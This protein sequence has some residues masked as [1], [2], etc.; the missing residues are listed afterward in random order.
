VSFQIAFLI[1]LVAGPAS[2]S[3][4]STAIDI[5]PDG[6]E[7]WVVNP[8]H[9]SVSVFGM[10]GGSA[11][12]L[13]AEI[14]VGRE[15]W[16]VDV[17][18][19][20]G[21][22]W[23]TSMRDDH[24]YILDG[25]SRTVVDSVAAGFETFGVAFDP[26]GTVA[27][28]T[29]SGSDEI[30]VVDVASRAITHTFDVYR[31]P[32]GIA[33]SHDGTRA[34]VS[35]LLMPEYFGKLT[36][37]DAGSWT[38]TQINLQ[39]VFGL[40]RGGYLSSMQNIALAP[41][42]G[43]SILW[44]PNTLINT[45]S[46]D[47]SGHPLTPTNTFHAVV[48]PINVATNTDLNWDTYFLSEGGTPNSGFAGGTTPVGGP[49]AV[50]FGTS[51][52]YVANL[53]SE[54]VTVLGR[55]ILAPQELT[56]LPAGRAPIGV[57]IHT[58]IARVYVANWLS[59]D[60]TV[61]NT[62]SGT[63]VATVPTTTSEVLSPQ[64]LNGKQFFFTSTGDMSLED[65]GSCGSC[66]V[67]GRTDGRP[68]D[69]SQFGTHIRATKDWRGVG[70]TGPLLWSANVD[71]TQDF[72]WT[73]RDIMGGAGLIP[74]TPNPA[75]GD[76]NAGLSQDLDDIAF[77]V[78]VQQQRPDTPFLLPDGS[79]TAEA[80]S[81][82]ILFNDPSVACLVCHPPP[83]FTDSTFLEDPWI[84]HDVGTADSTDT[85]GTAGYDTPSLVG[86]WDSAPYLHHHR[87]KTLEEMMT[88]LNPD[89]RH[90][91]TSQLSPEQIGFLAAYVKSIG[92]PDSPGPPTGAPSGPIVQAPRSFDRVFPNPFRD[93]TS[94]RF[95]VEG[96]LANVRI[97]V[98]D[99]TGRRV[100]DLLDR[101]LTRGTHV[102]GWDSRDQN[103][104]PVA[105]GA[106]FA[107][108]LVDDRR[109]GTKRMTV[110]R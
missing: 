81:G 105:S 42:P 3:S 30:F 41:A 9:A 38:L 36:A 46:G 20:N 29:A 83:F 110:L 88:T 28:V 5:S 37:I 79:L 54:N 12:M 16:C 98:F 94:L 22:V 45:K 52:A 100:R 71:E 60:V 11:N 62:A 59:R 23:V 90:G 4:R 80:D 55:D 8:D 93:E 103:G 56:V 21:E 31:R 13:L 17:H 49:V 64:V 72:E 50:A 51:R 78:S 19:T 10:Q 39:Q 63:V 33:W 18:P 73:I 27:L 77:F 85:L 61:L 101:D 95:H 2:A 14:P 102:V 34:W 99:V 96:S 7:G 25:A 53:H 92:W 40:D 109:V 76:P 44:I 67:F 6:L 108:L 104:R 66:H 47:L 89:D 87:A 43:D 68:W 35:H 82:R 15:P 57:A 97:E 106:Y 1:T 74:G 26:A 69:F 65:R 32:R 84:L 75:L 48:R 91:F 107:R 70:Y 58:A 86:A 24:V